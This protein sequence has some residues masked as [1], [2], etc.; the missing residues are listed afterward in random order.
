MFKPCWIARKS[1]LPTRGKVSASLFI[2]FF[3]LFFT[4]T[5]SSAHEVWAVSPLQFDYGWFQ[6]HEWPFFLFIFLMWLNTS[7]S[8]CDNQM[9]F[10]CFQY[11][12]AFFFQ[13]QLPAPGVHYGLSWQHCWLIPSHCSWMT[14]VVCAC[15]VM[16]CMWCDKDVG[17]LYFVYALS[18]LVVT[19]TLILGKKI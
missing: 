9:L 13:C 19:H 2:F 4:N 16:Q 5:F 6:T 1:K 14:G 3:F 18:D 8:N 10:C 12:M 11:D 7:T 17:L 15:G